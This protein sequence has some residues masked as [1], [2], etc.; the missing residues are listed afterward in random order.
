MGFLSYAA[1][2]V[3]MDSFV[4]KT[5]FES[6]RTRWISANWDHW[7]EQTRKYLDVRTSMD[8]I[9][10]TSA[11]AI[12]A[13]D[14]VSSSLESG[15][16]IVSTGHLPDRIRLW[17]ELAGQSKSAAAIK[18][19]D[20]DNRRS[21]PRIPSIYLGPRND[22]ERAIAE[23]W[24]EV[25]GVEEVGVNDDFFELGGHSLL[26]TSLIARVR[27]ITRVDLPLK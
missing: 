12:E 5:A 17:I 13:F 9:S 4:A 14:R 15:Q 19:S 20:K 16:V 21:R 27:E 26:V 25:L 10:M 11:E 1:A 24:A 7:P 3:A 8:E 22:L 18:G 2:N 23:V 6:S